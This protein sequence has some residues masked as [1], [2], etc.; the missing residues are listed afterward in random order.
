MP[1]DVATPLLLASASPRRREL[2][3]LAGVPTVVRGVEA[4]ESQE[5]AETAVGY[6]ERVVHTKLTLAQRWLHA[7]TDGESKRPSVAAVLVADTVVIL[8]SRG[9]G[10]P[11]ERILGKPRD[12]RD[13]RELISVLQG[14]EHAVMTRYAIAEPGATRPFAGDVVTTWVAF[15]RLGPAGIERYV[16]TGEGFDKAGGYAIQGAGAQLVERIEGSYTNVV[17]LPLCEVISALERHGLLAA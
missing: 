15:R 11:R 8:R 3:S 9:G 1:I 6:L 13:A 2:L 14:R 10:G 5:Q 17:G 4:E 12:E 7:A 16:A